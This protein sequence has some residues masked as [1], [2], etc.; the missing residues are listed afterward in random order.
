MA[1]PL[2]DCG[3]GTRSRRERSRSLKSAELMDEQA[4]DS[5][6]S[7]VT[8][9]AIPAQFISSAWCDVSMRIRE[10]L[11]G[12]MRRE[13]AADQYAADGTIKINVLRECFRH[14]GAQM[15]KVNP[16]KFQSNHLIYWRRGSESNRRTRLC[17]PLHDHSA[18]PPGGSRTGQ[19]CATAQ[20]KRESAGSPSRF[21][22]GKGVSNSRPQPWQG[23]ALPTE[24]FP[25]RTTVNYSATQCCVKARSV[26]CR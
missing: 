18:T 13:N 23:C 6:S 16:H 19:D 3:N 4:A 10:Q 14:K 24:L 15:A 21:W 20:T 25:R 5:C 8:V 2:S 11:R 9:L 26:A 7:N 1:T 12:S 22:S 17:R